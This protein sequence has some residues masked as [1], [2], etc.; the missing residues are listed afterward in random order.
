MSNNLLT[1]VA[2]RDNRQPEMDELGFM[3]GDLLVDA[4]RVDEHWYVA[5]KP[6][7]EAGLVPA[8]YVQQASSDAAATKAAKEAKRSSMRIQ[9]ERPSVR[10]PTLAASCEGYLYKKGGWRHNWKKRWFCIIGTDLAYADQGGGDV[11]S[12]AKGAIDLTD[13]ELEANPPAHHTHNWTFNVA[14]TERTYQLYAETKEDKIRW[15]SALREA[16]DSAKGTKS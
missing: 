8:S 3:V 4:K 15:V 12:R 7:G 14:V 11:L 5:V 16:I 10:E 13:A 6:T 1:L 9:Q 2:V